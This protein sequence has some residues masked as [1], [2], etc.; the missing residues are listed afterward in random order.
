MGLPVI[1]CEFWELCAALVP[2]HAGDAD[3]IA[4]LH[5]VWKQGVPTPHSKVNDPA[6]FDER[7]NQRAAGNRVARIVPPLQLAE[8]IRQRCAAL[9]LEVVPGVPLTAEDAMSLI[10]GQIP[11]IHT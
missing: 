6:H 5:D 9:G 2:L 7:V 11:Q 1:T 3:K 10:L 8:W 4:S